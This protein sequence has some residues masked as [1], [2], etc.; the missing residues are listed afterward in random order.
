MKS[1]TA[2][3]CAV[4]GL[5]AASGAPAEEGSHHRHAAPHGGTL[6]VLGQEFAHLELVLDPGTGELDVYVLDGEAAR[7][8]PVPQGRIE[9]EVR[10][11]SRPP[12][13][14]GLAPVENVLT[15]EREGSTSHFAG[16]FPRLRGA[17]R[18]DA[19]IRRIEVRGQTFEGVSFEFPDGNEHHGPGHHEPGSRQEEGS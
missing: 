18:F 11:E 16:R 9:I 17:S 15:G 12:F 1:S 10:R 6:V 2:L 4:V 3:L 19:E 7:G 13:R 14:L 5:S 8:V